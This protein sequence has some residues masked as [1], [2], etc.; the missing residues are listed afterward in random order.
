MNRWRVLTW[1]SALVALA[2]GVVVGVQAVMLHTQGWRVQLGNVAEW[3]A[4]IGTVVAIVAVLFAALGYRHDV[5]ARVEDENQR[6][7][8]ERRQQSELLSG[9]FVH[10]G[11]AR[12]GPRIEDA[13]AEII[14]VAQV[15]L[16]NASQVVIYDL[17]VVA[18]C[19]WQPHPTPVVVNFDE[20]KLVGRR[21]EGLIEKVAVQT[22]LIPPVEWDR[23]RDCLAVGSA[24][25]VAPGRWSIELRLATT[26]V[27]P[28]KL[29]LFFRDHR[30]VHWWRDAIGQLTELPVPV[31]DQNRAARVRLIEKVLGEE[32]TDATV[33]VLALKP[34]SE[35]AAT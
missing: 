25:V 12:Y 14:N 33:G 11:S 4:A 7:T 29:H 9:W 24:K 20:S 19:R 18:L 10:F 34:L 35:A 30:G 28:D 31:D 16:I 3:I 21:S 22:Q 5:R 1:I 32:P 8:S 13:P 23:P 15:G 26:S 27:V 2:L 6:I 17:F